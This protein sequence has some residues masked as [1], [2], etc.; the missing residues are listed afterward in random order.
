VRVDHDERDGRVSECD[1]PTR[2]LAERQRE[3]QDSALLEAGSP[4]AESHVLVVP[5]ELVGGRHVEELARFRRGVLGVAVHYQVREL[6]KLIVD[7]AS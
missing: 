1:S 4:C 2:L 3:H 5:G 6:G 7:L